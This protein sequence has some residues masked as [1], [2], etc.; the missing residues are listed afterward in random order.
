[1]GFN[2]SNSQYYL[3]WFYTN[4]I[5]FHM[6]I[7]RHTLLF[8]GDTNPAHPKHTGN[9]NP[10]CNVAHTVKDVYE[11]AKRLCEQC[12]L[13]DPELEVEEVNAKVLGKP[14]QVVYVTSYLFHMLFN[15]SVRTTIELH[16]ELQKRGLSGC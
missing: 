14:I 4:C 10:T 8:G 13:V 11:A 6:H 7:N 1:M 3:D 12:Q 15:N 2:S 9:I 16:Q 5:S